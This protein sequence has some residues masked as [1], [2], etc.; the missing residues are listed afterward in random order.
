MQL[1]MDRTSGGK[2]YAARR[3]DKVFRRSILCYAAC[4]RGH[5]EDLIPI[6]EGVCIPSEEADVLLVYIDI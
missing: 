1:V 5:Q 4:N 2:N 6:L 3:R